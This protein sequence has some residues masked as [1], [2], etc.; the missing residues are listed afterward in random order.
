MHG[1]KPVQANPTRQKLR[2]KITPARRISRSRRQRL[3][4]TIRLGPHRSTAAHHFSHRRPHFHPLLHFHLSLRRQVRRRYQPS[5]RFRA[6]WF[7]L[8]P[9]SIHCSSSLTFRRFIE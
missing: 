2:R 1:T 5:L 6:V 3:A 4:A 9:V 7:L 8:F